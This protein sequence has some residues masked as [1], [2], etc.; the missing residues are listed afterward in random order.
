MA[1]TNFFQALYRENF[2]APNMSGSRT[3][4]APRLW[5]GS[6]V[7]RQSMLAALM[8][9][10]TILC[11]IDKKRERR[12]FDPRCIHIYK[13]RTSSYNALLPAASVRGSR[14]GKRRL[15]GT[16]VTGMYTS[17][18]EIWL[19][20]VLPK[21]CRLQHHGTTGNNQVIPAKILIVYEVHLAIVRGWLRGTVVLFFL[22]CLLY[23]C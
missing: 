12:C 1:R 3:S 13:Y 6:C 16:Y 9:L 4:G 10:I 11:S 5:D 22:L 18:G 21:V 2:W 20:S 19:F 8:M 15:P 14:N 7:S 23:I 17:Y